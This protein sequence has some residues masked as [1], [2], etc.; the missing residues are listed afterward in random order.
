STTIV[1]I[2]RYPDLHTVLALFDPSPQRSDDLL[3]LGPREI[4]EKQMILAGRIGGDEIERAKR[5]RQKIS[6]LLVRSTSVDRHVDHPERSRRCSR[7]IALLAKPRLEVTVPPQ[8]L[9][10]RDL[11][12]ALDDHRRRSEVDDLSARDGRA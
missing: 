4:R 2:H 11:G 9:E 1:G 12:Q 6:D 7:A 10:R 8:A 5:A 3:H